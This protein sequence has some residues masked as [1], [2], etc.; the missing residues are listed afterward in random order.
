MLNIV[1]VKDNDMKTLITLSIATLL[2]TSSYANA[3]TST[4]LPFIGDRYFS[5]YF[6]GNA[7]QKITISPN[8]DTTILFVGFGGSEIQ[9]KGKFTNPLVTTAVDGFEHRYKFHG[10]KISEVDEKGRILTCETPTYDENF[11]IKKIPCTVELQKGG[12]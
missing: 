10:N 11:T 7:G 4:K 3:Q 12:L 1:L 5:F 8:G 2:M 6:G 9:Y